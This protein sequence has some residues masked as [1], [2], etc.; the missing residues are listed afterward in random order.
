MISDQIPEL[1]PTS[2]VR[3]SDIVKPWAQKSPDRVALVEASGTWSY[4][5]LWAAISQTQI[6]LEG[7]GTRPGDRVMVVCENCRASV[8]IFLALGAMDAWPVLVNAR[9]SAQ[10]ID[11]IRVHCGARRLIYTVGVSVHARKHAQRH[12]ASV[13]DIPRPRLAGNRP[14]VRRCSARSSGV[15]PC[16]QCRRSDL[17]FGD[18]GTPQGRH[19]HASQCFVCSERV[20]QDQSIDAKRPNVR[21]PA[22][23]P[24]RGADRGNARDV[25][26]WCQPPPFRAIRS[27]RSH[28]QAGTRKDYGHVGSAGAVC[29]AGRLCKAQGDELIKISVPQDHF[30]CWCSTFTRDQVGGRKV[31]WHRAP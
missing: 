20:I 31:F 23:L 17:H 5:Q 1:L 26:Q 4:S 12:D 27:N 15:R 6:W 8:A 3:A 13:Q 14:A 25:T 7:L 24:C 9:L 28:P 22:N 19:A 21:C 2:P 16:G 10:E 11:Q 29:P 18:Y 30:L